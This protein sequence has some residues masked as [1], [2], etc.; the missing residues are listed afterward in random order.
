MGNDL[1]YVVQA[2]VSSCLPLI[3]LVDKTVH[4]CIELLNSA[5]IILRHPTLY[6]KQWISRRQQKATPGPLFSKSYSV[7]KPMF[8][9]IM[10]MTECI[11]MSFFTY[12]T[13]VVTAAIQIGL[14]MDKKKAARSEPEETQVSSELKDDNSRDLQ[15]G[16]L[17]RKQAIAINT[18]RE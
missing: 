7:S 13:A 6:G 16:D 18:E 4:G 3:C 9:N 10:D 11:L 15:T 17:D 1:A 12:F 2:V 8:Q 5:R 14:W